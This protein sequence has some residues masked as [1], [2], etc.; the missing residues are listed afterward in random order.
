MDLDAMP[1]ELVDLENRLRGRPVRQRPADLRDRVLRA[2]AESIRRERTAATWPSD[3]WLGAAIAAAALI[4]MN[5]ST[6]WASPISYSPRAASSSNQFG[7][8][9]QALRL[10]ESRQEGTSK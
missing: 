2:T 9:L 10:Y 6:F 7:A 3:G 5:L 1:S 8:E 4:A